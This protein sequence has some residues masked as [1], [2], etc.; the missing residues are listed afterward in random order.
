MRVSENMRKI[1]RHKRK[2]QNKILIIGSLLLLLFLCVG[3]AAFSINL[4]ITAKGNIKEK[5]RVIQSWNST[6][7]TDFHSDFYKQ[8]ILSITFLDNNKVP[9]NAMESW[10]VS[11]NKENGEV[12]AW[13]VP[14]NND[15]T[16]YDLYIGAPAG[17]IANEDSSYMFYKFAEATNIDLKHLDTSNTLN[18]HSMFDQ[19]NKA[20]NIDVSNFNTI[21]VINM[22]AMFSECHSLENIDLSSFDTS[23]VTNMS[24]MFYHNY[25]LLNLDINNFNTSHVINME[26]MFVGCRSLQTLDVSNFDTSNVTDM[27]HMFQDLRITQL[28]LCNFDTL[29]VTDMDNMFDLSSNLE[30]VYVGL[31]W[32]MEN[33]ISS[34]YMFAGTKISQ[35]TT[36]QC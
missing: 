16:K 9:S 22:L 1:G 12:M 31:N 6:D 2:K 20:T 8:N 29:K 17:V 23:N 25:N 5:T 27:S 28:N 11:E 13:V 33:V 21:N 19:C 36:G 34:D 35:V 14:N 4:S 7:Q 26:Q 30:V 24:W 3:Y 15:N 10:N 18:M 32:S